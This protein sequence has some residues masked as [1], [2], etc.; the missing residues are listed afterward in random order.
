MLGTGKR[1]GG[2][3]LWPLLLL[4]VSV[5]AAGPAHILPVTDLRVLGDEA[6]R[7]H[8]VIL[9][10]VTTRWCTYCH[11][12]KADFLRPMLVSGDYR[13]RLIMRELKLDDTGTIRDFAGKITSARALG[14]AYGVNLTPTL[15]FLGPDGRELA[16]RI[17]GLTTPDFFGGYI[18]RGIEQA[19]RALPP[20]P[21]SASA[22]EDDDG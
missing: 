5:R 12:L 2:A 4:A 19:L 7:S 8:R 18:D 1:R 14:S 17:Q 3:I 22:P 6:R 16:Q 9:L 15:L 20:A 11:Q 10:A 21:A 13:D